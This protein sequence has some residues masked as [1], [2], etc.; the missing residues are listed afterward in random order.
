MTLAALAEI[1][2]GARADAHEDDHALRAMVALLADATGRGC[3]IYRCEEAGTDLL[4]GAHGGEGSPPAPR[5]VA[6]W[7]GAGPASAADR[8]R[9]ESG[10][11]LVPA[12]WAGRML[13]A[14][15]L[16]VG[17]GG[18]RTVSASAPLVGAH[19]AARSARRRAGAD[20]TAARRLADRDAV[21]DARGRILGAGTE[22]AMREALVRE[23][24]GLMGADAALLC[25]LRPAGAPVV[26]ASVGWS[27]D[28]TPPAVV[29]LAAPAAGETVWL[30]REAAVRWEPVPGDEDEPHALVVVRRAGRPFGEDDLAR[31]GALGEAVGEAFAHARLVTRLRRERGERQALAAMG[32]RPRQGVP[33]GRRPGP[34]G[35][36]PAR[37]HRHRPIPE[38]RA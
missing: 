30:G 21:G 18:E 3:A 16:G 35:L 26:V 4:L 8:C 11:L 9:L 37:R 36:L 2:E 24:A 15:W 38:R 10:A 29:R 23:A 32:H 19:L 6:L 27:G 14:L 1:C 34:V 31:L 5:L 33:A 25:A 12:C 22:G 17:E 13:G 20:A 7:P 28:R